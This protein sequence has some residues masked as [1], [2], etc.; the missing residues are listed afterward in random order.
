MMAAA[1]PSG[2]E[3]TAVSGPQRLALVELY[4]SEGCSSCPPADRW[5]SALRK[6][7]GLTERIVPLA[8]HVDYWNKLGWI[9]PYA[10]P[11]FSERQSIQS[12]RRGASFVFT[13]QIL[14]SGRDYRRGIVFDD[15][16]RRVKAINDSKPGASIRFEAA[17]MPSGWAVALTSQLAGDVPAYA[18]QAFIA[19]YENVPA[20]TI[21]AGENRGLTLS[22]AY[23]V[24][25][26][27][28]PFAFDDSGKLS[29]KEMLSVTARPRSDGFGLA[30]FV[31]D[32][33]S[34][35]VYQAASSLCN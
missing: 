18:A 26:L 7:K 25:N 28:G 8:F 11:A 21:T 27:A 22:H 30:A 3:C 23:V 24:R 15:F 31:Q 9:D 19:A 32:A 33:R 5:L 29:V 12:R 6:D 10:Q 17:R 16:D 2:A 13:P 1:S 35:D 4:T 14:V 20:T 34:G